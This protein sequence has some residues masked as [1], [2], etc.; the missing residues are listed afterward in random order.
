MTK[1][2]AHTF[3]V[4]NFK[5]YAG[6]N[7]YLNKS[8][9]VFDFAV[10]SEGNPLPIYDYIL[11][12]GNNFTKLRGLICNSYADLFA[13]NISYVNKLE[14]N[15]HLDS[16]SLKN[17][18]NYNRIALHF[19]DYK[20]TYEVIHFVWD[21][22]EAITDN[23][24]FDPAYKL[25]KLQELFSNSIYG[26]PTHYSLIRSAYYK[27]IPTFFLPSE[28]LI[29]YGY[30]KY[31]VRGFSTTFNCDSHLD[32]DFTTQKDDCKAFLESAGFPVPKGQ[33]VY[34]L[35]EALEVVKNLSYPVAVK[36]VVGH[37]GIGVTANIPNDHELEFALGKAQN[38]CHHGSHA[39]IVEQYIP[40][41][42]FRL[43]CVGGKFVAA[44]ERR[45]PFVVG[46]GYF[47][48]RSLIEKENAT[49]ARRDT[50]ISALGK[51][52]TDDVMDE[53]LYEQGLK[54]DS[55]IPKEQVVYL[56]KVANLSSGG[57]SIDVTEK[58]HPD[59]M[60]LAQDIAQYFNL[61]CLGIDAITPDI[62]KSW[63]EG[64][65]GII[66]INAAP[67]VFMHLNPA[68]GKPVDVP[69]R[70]MEY[71]FPPDKPCRIPIVTF[72]RLEKKQVD[73]IIDHI[74]LRHPHWK[75]G[76]VCQQ[77]IWL[78]HSEKV[79]VKDYNINVQRLLRHPKLD[80]LI[81]EYPEHIF[82][83]QGMSYEGSDLMILDEPTEI[84]MILARDLLPDGTLIIKR[85]KHISVN[86]KG[87]VE[88]YDLGESESF[89]Y[90]YLKA[91][92]QLILD[93]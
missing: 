43:L 75:I 36:P 67:G 59:N 24:N 47:T 89:T 82:A 10:K 87:Y 55:I 14:M 60:I 37:K 32:S 57:V 11:T 54:L 3:D 88:S 56:R 35:N 38:A 74:L 93:I 6:P 91:I 41:S 19:L 63:K 78:N 70:I 21:W 83:E 30:G 23:R 69:S 33:I 86:A 61:V 50:P 17:Q 80:L 76:T 13:Q 62:S 79:P 29:Q 44:L 52:I 72:N 5:D 25:L 90:I 48:L 15:L 85:G 53:Y 68:I 20:S 42:D 8:A 28:S 16:Y 4:F 1:N 73:E 12:I 22:L 66:E 45:P 18:G 65:F 81:A 64:N 31:Q 51:I 49:P 92:T 71:L 26:G 46:D 77:G 40:G 58:V 27:N 7:P 39:I 2:N 9:I 84:E 34:D